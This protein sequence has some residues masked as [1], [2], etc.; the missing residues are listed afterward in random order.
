VFSAT[1]KRQNKALL[2]AKTQSVR[3]AHGLAPAHGAGPGCSI[4]KSRT[5]S[6]RCRRRRAGALW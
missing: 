1:T 3:Y 5:N 6:R 4:D 2:A